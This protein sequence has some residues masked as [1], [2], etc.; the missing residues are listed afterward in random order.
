MTK[1]EYYHD[2][3]CGL[4]NVYIKGI[5]ETIDDM[6]D[7]VITIP[8]PLELHKSLVLEVLKKPSKLNGEEIRFLRTE[9]GLTQ[10]ELSEKFDNSLK[11]IQR[12]ENEKAD[13]GTAEDVM[14]RLLV[15]EKNGG[16]QELNDSN[17]NAVDN[18][19]ENAKQEKIVDYQYKISA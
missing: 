18:V 5:V 16:F 7:K 14:L 17:W 8:K 10:T 19:L 4:S 1:S 9:L 6:G 3:S 13:I 12:W 15:D 11:T 2:K